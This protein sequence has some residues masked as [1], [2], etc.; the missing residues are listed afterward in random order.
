MEH[1]L[2]HM[3]AACGRY[4]AVM[5]LQLTSPLRKPETIDC[6]LTEFEK[7]GADSMLGVVESHAFFWAAGERPTASY[8]WRQRPRR[9]DIAD[10]DRRFRETG[11]L[12]ITRRDIFVESGNRLAGQIRLFPM[13]ECEGW[14]IDTLA[15]FAVVEALMKQ[16]FYQ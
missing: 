8:D 2:R 4:D 10:A 11:S 3:E 14:E 1:A 5:L 7:S 13:D 15:D 12:Y 6:A 16:E 9:Q